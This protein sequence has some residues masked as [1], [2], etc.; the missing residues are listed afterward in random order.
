MQL[1]SLTIIDAALRK[2]SDTLARE[3]AA[4]GE[5]QPAWNEFEWRMARA[6]A[7][8]HG[9]SP[10]L[11]TTLRWQGPPAFSTFLQQQRAEVQARHARIEQLLQQLDTAAQAAGIAMLA[12]KGASLHRM[13][14]CRAGER[15]MADI[16]LLVKPQ[17][18]ERAAQ[19]ICGQGY[20]ESISSWRH[21][22]FQPADA[23]RELVLGERADLPVKIEVHTGI[24]ERLPLSEVHITDR[25]TATDTPGL[26]LYA[27]IE[28][29]MLHQ[30]LHAAGNMSVRWLRML[31]LHDIARIAANMS[32]Q[33]WERL[34][35][36]GES[37]SRWWWAY[38]PLRLTSRYFPGSI[39]P[40]VLES[41]AAVCPRALRIRADRYVLADV[42]CAGLWVTAAP[43]V[44]WAPDLPELVRYLWRRIR[45][46]QEDLAAVGKFARVQ[47][48]AAKDSWYSTSQW[49]RAVKWLT[50][51]PARPQI[52]LA[53]RLAQES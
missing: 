51:R 20:L 2:T 53:V 29:T 40:R 16:D 1:P 47:T 9:I 4:P 49:R 3:L 11:A 24:S 30:L 48:W 34:A 32:A 23:P 7:A 18:G 13:G 41:F 39:P 10:L 5:L 35:G 8:I 17:D 45:P 36:P 26:Q 6:A 14:F 37:V 33:D 21:R 15:P 42:S 46:S 44:A 31:Q 27:S 52:L 28:A 43:A 38:P 25:L 22:C 19:L 50:S 12:L